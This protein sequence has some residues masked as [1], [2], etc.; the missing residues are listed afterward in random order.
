V[1]GNV[2]DGKVRSVNEFTG[3]VMLDR[4]R[5]SGLHQMIEAK[6]GVE[7]TGRKLTL[8]R[9]TYR[10]FFRHYHH[11]TGM[12]GTAMEVASVYHLGIIRV[13]TDRPSRRRGMGTHL[14]TETE[15]K[16]AAIAASAQESTTRGWSVLIGTRSVETS[17]QISGLLTE[18]NLS[19]PC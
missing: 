10:R 16:W 18:A 19:T 12:T 4:S 15:D 1:T 2:S 7:I 3:R 5:E 6:E 13:P 14:F 11:L 17:E 8:T 9:I